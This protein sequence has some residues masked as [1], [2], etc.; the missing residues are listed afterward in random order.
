MSDQES[1]VKEQEGE[2]LPRHYNNI[3]EILGDR[4]AI[5]SRHM[6]ESSAPENVDVI[7]S[8]ETDHDSDADLMV[9]ENEALSSATC[10]QNLALL[11][12]AAML[13]IQTMITHLL[14]SSKLCF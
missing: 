4:E 13:L 1:Q 12:S 7:S 6:L 5:N 10:S 9:M 2:L 8:P 11:V 3:D 14:Q